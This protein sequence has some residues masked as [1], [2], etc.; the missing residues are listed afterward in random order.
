MIFKAKLHTDSEDEP[1]KDFYI[2]AES[3]T[4]F[5]IPEDIEGREEKGINIFH[6]GGL[7]TIMQEKHITDYL[8]KTFVKPSIER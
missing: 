2:K 7:S 6:E 5:Y 4:G 3:I 1:F 8:Y